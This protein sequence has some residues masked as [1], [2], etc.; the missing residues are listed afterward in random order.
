L[1]AEKAIPPR[2]PRGDPEIEVEEIHI[3]G[4]GQR[5]AEISR[6]VFVGFIESKVHDRGIRSFT[7]RN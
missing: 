4:R 7:R 5:V 1:E 2:R 6:D 3:V